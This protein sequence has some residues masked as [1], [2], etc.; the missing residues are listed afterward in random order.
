[1]MLKISDKCRDSI[2]MCVCKFHCPMQE[3]RAAL[4]IPFLNR[5]N[6]LQRKRIPPET[7]KTMNAI[8]LREASLANR[9][10]QLVSK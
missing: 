1:M 2:F 9:T 3:L 4:F 5:N 6:E 10:Q 8:G 7:K